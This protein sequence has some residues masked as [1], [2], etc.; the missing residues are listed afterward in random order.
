[1]FVH[2]P[3]VMRGANRNASRTCLPWTL[4]I[5]F[6]SC[7]ILE[8]IFLTPIMVLFSVSAHAYAGGQ[9]GLMCDRGR[10]IPSGNIGST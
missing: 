4:S 9:P 3:L 1:M 2:V 7:A 10:F 6:N 5:S 8:R